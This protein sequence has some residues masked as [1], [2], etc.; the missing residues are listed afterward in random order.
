MIVQPEAEEK[1]EDNYLYVMVDLSNES[2]AAWLT[3]ADDRVWLERPYDDTDHLQEKIDVAHVYFTQTKADIADTKLVVGLRQAVSKYVQNFTVNATGS[4]AIWAE[5]QTAENFDY[6][7]SQQIGKASAADFSG[8]YQLTSLVNKLTINFTPLES[9]FG[10]PSIIK[11]T[12]PKGATR[13]ATLPVDKHDNTNLFVAAEGALYLFTPDGQKN[14]GEAIPIIKNEIFTDTVNFYAHQSSLGTV[15]YGLNKAG[16]VFYSRCSAG[17][18]ANPDSWAYPMPI[19]T[20]IKQMG[21]FLNLENGSSVIFAQTQDAPASDPTSAGNQLIH[22]TQDPVTTIWNQQNILLPSSNPNSVVEY[23]SY[24]THIQL[25]DENNLPLVESIVLL[26]TTSPCNVYINDSY[27]VL[28]AD[29]ETKIRSDLAGK[30]NIVQQTQDLNVVCY[31]FEMEEGGAAVDE[32]PMSK[33]IDRMATVPTGGALGKVTITDEQ[34]VSRPLIPDTVTD[35]EKDITALSLQN[36]VLIA[37]AMPQDGSLKTPD[38]PT[39][40]SLFVGDVMASAEAAWGVSYEGN[41]PQFYQGD[42]AVK[43]LFLQ[44]RQAT[45]GDQ[46]SHGLQSGDA[47]DYIET[48]AGDLFNWLKIAYQDVK[49]FFTIIVEGINYFCIRLAEGLFTFV[50]N[51]ISDVVNTV[52]FI[53]SKVSVYMERLVEWLGFIF[54]WK[55]MLLTQKAIKNII[56]QHVY[57]VTDPKLID[58]YKEEMKLLFQNATKYIDEW[59]GIGPIEGSVVEATKAEPPSEEQNSPQVNW[60][61]SQFQSNVQN[62]VSKVTVTP[63][64]SPELETMLLKLMQLIEQE[65]AIFEK[66]LQVIQDQIIGQLTTLSIGELL[67]RILAVLADILIESIENILEITID[68]IAIIIKGVI[69]ILDTPINVPVISWAYKKI[70]GSESSLLDVVCLVAAIPVTILYKIATG[71]APFP[72][73]DPFTLEVIN[74]PNWQELQQLY[75]DSAKVPKKFT[76]LDSQESNVAA[77]GQQDLRSQANMSHRDNL[78]MILHLLA[79]VSTI[80]F[81]VLSAKKKVMDDAMWPPDIKRPVY[82]CHGIFFYC[83]T[84]PNLLNLLTLTPDKSIKIAG[85]VIYG[86]TCCQKLAD[87]FT[88]QNSELA[89]LWK[90]ISKVSDC[91]LGV[92]GMIPTILIMT[93]KVEEDDFDAHDVIAYLGAFSWN[94]NRIATPFTKVDPHVLVFKFGAQGIY[95]IMQFL[96]FFVHLVETDEQSKAITDKRRRK[97]HNFSFKRL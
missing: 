21:S 54:E 26:T 23:T 41:T 97:R 30:I 36:L 63:G 82:I 89:K 91:I 37:Q 46:N 51:C 56:K 14:F 44:D 55:D 52:E 42:A 45:F 7:K 40:R 71:Q 24:T 11:L 39:G 19:L 76:V 65:G 75:N 48:T 70:T 86:I 59:A 78:E 22:M 74:A 6:V 16:Q 69:E 5:L 12:A 3:S 68:V 95:G 18:E 28:S 73:E 81:M 60:S 88:Y 25:S 10:P 72:E 58:S 85:K 29:T 64:T 49:E 15:I 34:G 8:L 47:L 32:N 79:G 17:E 33:L 57:H 67:K 53:F 61:T 31:H 87:I 38:L 20:D 9:M 2:D 62:S 77:L 80:C 1:P 27:R 83:T 96:L 92:A 94:L 35:Q 66:A 90:E 84:S 4:D 50:I 93:D 13:L 43:K